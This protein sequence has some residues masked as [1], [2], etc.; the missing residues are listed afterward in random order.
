[1]SRLKRPLEGGRE[2]DAARSPRRFPPPWS[3]EGIRGHDAEEFAALHD[4]RLFKFSGIVQN[5]Q[6]DAIEDRVVLD[7]VSKQIRECLE[8]AEGCAREA[9]ELPGSSSFRHDFLE[10]QNRW[11]ELAQTIE[12]GEQLCSFTK[13]TP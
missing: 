8:H 10:L 11:L 4:D 1:V 3:V 12:F 9:A 13:S 7:N 5:L 6:P 2:N